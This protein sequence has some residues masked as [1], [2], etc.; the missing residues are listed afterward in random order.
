MT[1]AAKSVGRSPRRSPTMPA[2]NA[3]GGATTNPTNRVAE[4]TRPSR[5][6]GVNAWTRLTELTTHRHRQA[7]ER[8]REPEHGRRLH[9]RSAREGKEQPAQRLEEK[10][11]DHHRPESPSRREG[12]RQGGAQETERPDRRERDAE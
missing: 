8:L 11:G 5:C 1:A 4:F 6:S 2:P 12:S 10:R 3:A 7:E 9:G